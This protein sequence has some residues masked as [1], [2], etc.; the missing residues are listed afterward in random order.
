LMSEREFYEI[1]QRGDVVDA[2]K[3]FETHEEEIGQMAL[4]A[5]NPMQ[6]SMAA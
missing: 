4:P 2:Q 5:P 3:D 1:L 6:G